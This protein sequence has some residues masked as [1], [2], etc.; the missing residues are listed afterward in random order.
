MDSRPLTLGIGTAEAQFGRHV[1]D[2]SGRIGLS[3]LWKLLPLLASVLL[4][5]ASSADAKSLRVLDAS[6]LGVDPPTLNRLNGESFQQDA[7][8][9]FNGE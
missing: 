1:V 6:T 4:I 3:S 2:G 7:V 9:T 8:V 5:W